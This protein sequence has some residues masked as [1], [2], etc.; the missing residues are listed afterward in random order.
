MKQLRKNERQNIAYYLTNLLFSGS[1]QL[2][3]T[4]P[5]QSVASPTSPVEH[6]N[7]ME[8]ET[9]GSMEKLRR[10]LI[11]LAGGAPGGSIGDWELISCE[12]TTQLSVRAGYGASRKLS[13]L[14]V[15]C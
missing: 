8:V 12:P 4:A 15:S 6:D 14:Q 7:S 1:E 10:E 5:S 13:F 11:G 9:E 2:P 3:P